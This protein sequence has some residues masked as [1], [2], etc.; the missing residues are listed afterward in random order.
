MKYSWSG[1]MMQ[2]EFFWPVLGS[3]S[4]TSVQRFMFTVPCGSVLG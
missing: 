1:V 4:M 2:R 3:E